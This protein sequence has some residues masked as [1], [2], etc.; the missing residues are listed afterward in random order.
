MV[1]ERVDHFA[2]EVLDLPERSTIHDRIQRLLVTLESAAKSVK[3]KVRALVGERI[4]WY[5]LPEETR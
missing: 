2:R 5:E 1:A 4:R 3:W